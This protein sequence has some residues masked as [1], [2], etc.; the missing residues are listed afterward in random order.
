MKD[1][2]PT[3]KEFPQ[4]KWDG[5]AIEFEADME[6]GEGK[7]KC[8]AS[9]GEDGRVITLTVRDQVGS[10]LKMYENGEWNKSYFTHPDDHNDWGGVMFKLWQ[11]SSTHH[12]NYRH[13]WKGKEREAYDAKVIPI[14]HKEHPLHE[15]IDWGNPSKAA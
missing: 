5:R 2:I 14:T 12:P 10:V 13:I 1:T 6:R 8:E 9:F 11:L 15:T 4:E 7:K 3:Y